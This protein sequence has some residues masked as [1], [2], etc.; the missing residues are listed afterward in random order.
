MNLLVTNTREIQAY[1]II[2]ALRPDADK[3]VATLS[4]KNPMVARLSHAANSRL[5]DGR[6]YVPGVENDWKAGNI[7]PENT[8]A[9]ERY[10]RKIIE[11]CAKERIDT[12][13]PSSDPQVYVFSK[14]KRRF[15][16]RGILIP[17]PDYHKM[18][19]PI[20]KYRTLKLAR[21]TGFPCPKTVL[22]ESEEDLKRVAGEL[23]PPWVI[24]P[25][26]TV[27]SIGMD[28]VAD[29]AELVEKI[30]SI[31]R[32]FGMPMLQEY[33]PGKARQSFFICL[34]RNGAL[35]EALCPECQRISHRIH[36]NTPAGCQSR[37]STPIS[38]PRYRC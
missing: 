16:K 21:E 9:E 7:Q 27:A 8:P 23:G 31:R 29:F 25:R 33:I 28:I 19:I 20:D 3:I 2:R 36:R 26:F 4:G 10:I 13:F 14:N 35:V 38:M 1:S 24:R 5:I 12:I 6:Y 11:I 17:V 15:A 34:D 32:H 22:P 30:K 37:G 18:I